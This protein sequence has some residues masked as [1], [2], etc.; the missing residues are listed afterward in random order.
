MRNINIQDQNNIK[1]IIEN[2]GIARQICT[3]SQLEPLMFNKERIKI[4]DNQGKCSCYFVINN[5]ISDSDIDYVYTRM[6][7]NYALIILEEYIETI[8][9]S[10]I[11]CRK[12]YF[13]ARES[14]LVIEFIDG[15]AEYFFHIIESKKYVK[16]DLCNI[17]NID[18]YINDVQKQIRCGINMNIARQEC[19]QH[20]IYEN[21]VVLLDNSNII[22]DKAAKKLKTENVTCLLEEW[23]FQNNN[24][25]FLY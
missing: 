4:Y 2:I 9:P 16:E 14:F 1:R 20:Y 7:E 6:V 24:Y 17:I 5:T 21:R 23:Y 18:K 11:W 15:R 22:L 13:N 12:E 19:I 8:V 3:I 25:R 10:K